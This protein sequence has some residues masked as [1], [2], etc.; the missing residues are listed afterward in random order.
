MTKNIVISFVSSIQLL[1]ICHIDVQAQQLADE[2][3]RYAISNPTYPIAH[4]PIILFDDSH[5]NAVTL[6]GTYSPFSRLL[7][8][9]G[10]RLISSTN[11]I[12]YNSL[13]EVKIYVTVNAM[14][15]L[16][17]WNLPGRSA[18][19]AQEIQILKQW[20]ADGGNLFLVTDHM[21]CGA[22]IHDLAAA[23]GI[24]VINGFALRR[25]GKPE[26]FSRL[27]NTLHANAI[28]NSPGQEIDSIMCW[29][30]TGFLTPPSAQIISSLNA[31]YT[32]YLPTDVRQ[33][34]SPLADTIPSLS[35]SGF[36]N[37]AYMSYGKGR[38]VIFGD[39]AIFSAQLYGVKS[40]KRGMNHPSAG[41]NAQLLLHLIHWLDRKR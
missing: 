38:I 23:F 35:G 28:T 3:Y 16:E 12:S 25:D 22:A 39:G 40:E 14:Y 7:K 8:M 32:I 20:V 4:G 41:Q 27:K 2:L 15:D 31:D 10:Y 24:H 11:Q 5:N 36:V 26:L 6:R 30:G 1:V 21:P 9:D 13:K 19:A 33:I 17:D 18:F 34:R 29:G 37:G